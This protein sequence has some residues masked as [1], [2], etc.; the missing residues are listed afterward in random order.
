MKK[1]FKTGLCLGLIASLCVPAF[2]VT[3]RLPDVTEEMTDAAY[4][5]KKQENNQDVLMTVSEAKSLTRGIMDAKGTMVMDLKTAAETFDGTARNTAIQSSAAEDARYYF[6]W[7]YLGKETKAT[8]DEY[9]S[10][11]DNCYDRT[12]RKDQP[13]RYGIAVKRTLVRVFPSYTPIWDDPADPDF[14]YQSLSGV[15]VNEPVL[16]YTT[17]ADGK[18]YLARIS[19]CSGWIPVEDVAICRDKAEWLSAWDLPEEDI[20]MVYG[21]KVYT[22]VSNFQSETSARMLTMGTALELVK[23]EDITPLIG[24]RAPYHNYVVYLPVRNA[25]GSYSKMAALIPQTAKVH[26]GYLP[27]TYENI[28]ELAFSTLGDA[29][30]WGGMMDV[31]DCSSMV[32][33]IYACFGIDIARNGN[34]QWN[35]PVAKVDLSYLSAAEK[36]AILDRLPL[37]TALCFSGHEMMY[38]GKTDGKYY[39]ISTVSKIMDPA[40][41]TKT[42]RVRGVVIN[43]LDIRRANGHTWLEDLNKA[44]MPAYGLTEGK[45][46]DFPKNEWYYDAMCFCLKNELMCSDENG[47]FVPNR[48]A[49]RGEVVEALWNAA[50]KPAVDGTMAFSDVPEDAACAPAVR[51]AA[52]EGIVRGVSETAFAPDAAVTREQLCTLLRRAAE[53][54]EKEESTGEAVPLS[55]YADAAQISTYAVDAVQW[56]L[57]EGLIKGTDAARLSPNSGCTRAQLATILMR[58]SA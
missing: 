54:Q 3:S 37:G 25:D 53:A 49:T 48:T 17:S 39:V 38:L 55:R 42:Q 41:S 18:F 15:R 24:N 26:I 30:G 35:M 33:M 50:K 34:W 5:I 21:P 19:C 12:A 23:Q 11:I 43:T 7:T 29:Y 6:G 10:L 45:H 47:S 8:W 40:D 1:I 58:Y 56:A 46:Y 31:E 14:D 51:W 16:I 52:S 36:C 9:Q 22:A 57:N 27:M 2:A 4:W 20:L 44:M 32:R 28:A 13:V